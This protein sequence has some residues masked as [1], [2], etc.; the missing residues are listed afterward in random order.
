MKN[1]SL[2]A[3]SPIDS[4]YAKSTNE[5]RPFFSEFALIKHRLW[6]EINWLIAMIKLSK[7]SNILTKSQEFFLAEIFTK[8]SLQDAKRI[9]AIEQK[10]NHDLKAVEYFLREKIAQN[11]Q[12]EKY[13][14]LIHFGCTSDDINN[15]AYAL[16]VKNSRQEVLLPNLNNLVKTL[17]TMA[18]KHANQPML[19]RTHGQPATPTTL[20]KEIA[21]F[22]FRLNC[23]IEKLA[24]LKIM[25]KINGAVGNFNAHTL[26]FPELDWP[27]ISQRFVNTL[28]LTCNPC[29]TQIEP[30]DYLAELANTLALINT[31]LIGFC[32]DLWGY[33]ALN[34]FKQKIAA[35]TV[36]SSTMPHKVNPIDF[37]NAE[38]NLGFANAMLNHFACKLPI[39]RWQRD[40]SDSTVLRNIGL[41]LAHS[42]LAYKSIEKGLNKITVNAEIIN[43]DLDKHWEVL[44][45]AVQTIMRQTGETHAYEIIKTLTHGLALNQKSYSLLVKQL[46]LSPDLEKKLLKLTPA[47]YLGSAAKIAKKI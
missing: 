46:N 26:A 12:L 6:V 22:S 4:R 32:R 28:G 20:G 43:L 1:E 44:G 11:K 15:L 16:M 24:Q 14:S 8:F 39:S 30:H 41:A 34:Y 18:K 23:Q 3:L 10:I 13:T 17:T 40:L 19:S 5:L 38:G 37:E 45:E 27:A 47:K 9:K 2:Y 42:I 31:I 21:N 25:G 29:T 36:G 33:I 7:K 35:T